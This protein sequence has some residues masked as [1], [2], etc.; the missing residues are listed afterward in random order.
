MTRIFWNRGVIWL[1]FWITSNSNSFYY[2]YI[3]ETIKQ[4]KYVT[5]HFDSILLRR[6]KWH[7][8]LTIYFRDSCQVLGAPTRT[9]S[10]LIPFEFYLLKH[11]SRQLFW[12][13]GK[14]WTGAKIDWPRQNIYESM[15]ISLYRLCIFTTHILIM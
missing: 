1:T 6:Q 2:A 9:Y 10:Y 5:F 7:L 13:Y 11:L 14:H 12:R 8:R 3:T 4:R 15:N